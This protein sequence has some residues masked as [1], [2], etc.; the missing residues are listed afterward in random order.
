MSASDI[1]EIGIVSL[2]AGWVCTVLLVDDD[3]LQLTTL[4]SLLEGAGYQVLLAK[5]GQEALILLQQIRCEIVVTARDMAGM[6]GLDLCRA[7]RLRDLRA[8]TYVLIL[9]TRRGRDDMLEGFS[10]GADDYL[11]KEAASDELLARLATGRRIARL[12][13]VL[14]SANAQHQRLALSDSLT[15]ARSRH[16]LAEYLPREIERA[17][18]YRR[19]LTILSCD[20]D[21]FKRVNDNFGHEA[22]DEVLRA[23]AER[24]MG[25][26]RHSIDWIARSGGEEFIIVLPETTLTGG[27]C[28]ASRLR[29]ALS[30]HPISTAA[31]A[32]TV[33]VSVGVSSIEAGDD[34]EGVTAVDLLRAADRCLYMSKRMGRDRATSLRAAHTEPLRGHRTG[35]GKHEL[36]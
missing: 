9:T 27:S 25:C 16:F 34:F 12:E 3:K 4:A 11:N 14:R 5:S 24:S 35:G 26:L 36:N 18:R 23:F 19:P 28:V 30:S 21:E 1:D 32:L 2:P 20:L 33:T 13:H 29:D 22:G 17:K 10:A 7:M 31:G 8:Y 15:G 6:S